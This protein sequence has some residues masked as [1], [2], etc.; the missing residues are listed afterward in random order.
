MSKRV[1]ILSGSPRKAGNSS[2]LCDQFM[3][4][5]QDAGHQVEKVPVAEKSV[6]YCVRKNWF[7]G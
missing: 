4:G 3:K 5:A 6:G 1:L 7:K 2:V